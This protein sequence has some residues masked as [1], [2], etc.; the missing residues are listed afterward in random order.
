MQFSCFQA[1]CADEEEAGGGAVGGD[2]V[3]DSDQ[4][5]QSRLFPDP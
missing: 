2:V 4:M 3:G 1:E 5:V